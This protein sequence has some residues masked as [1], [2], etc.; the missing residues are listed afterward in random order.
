MYQKLYGPNG[1]ETAGVLEDYALCLLRRKIRKGIASPLQDD[2]EDL[3]MH[4]ASGSSRRDP[5]AEEEEEEAD[6]EADSDDEAAQESC[7]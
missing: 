5:G 4:A 7:V 6:Q 2:D 3:L 1:L